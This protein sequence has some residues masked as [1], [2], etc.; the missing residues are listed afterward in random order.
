MPIKRAVLLLPLAIALIAAACGGGSDNNNSAGSDDQAR[1]SGSTAP[2]TAIGG[3]YG[4]QLTAI[5]EDIDQEF[6]A[7]S[8]EFDEVV[9][10]ALADLEGVTDAGELQTLLEE[11]FAK[12]F[13]A[14]QDFVP[15]AN[16]IIENGI[17]RI[18]ALDTP[19]EFEDDEQ[20]FL[21]AID[22]RLDLL[23]DL[24]E[25]A[26]D[27]D[28]EAFLALGQ[29]TTADDIDD[30]LRAAVSDDFRL[31]IAAFLDDDDDDD[32]DGDD[33]NT[34]SITQDDDGDFTIT[35]DDGTL[36]ID[37]DEGRLTVTDDDGTTTSIT[38]GTNGNLPD[39]V[40]DQLRYPNAV[41]ASA[42]TA[43]IDDALQIVL[44]FSTN[45]DPEDVLDFYEDALNAVGIRGDVQRG[46]IGGL[47]SLAI[48][49]AQQDG[50]GVI[51]AE[52]AGQ[53]ASHN[54]SVVLALPQ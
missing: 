31:L 35:S 15:R 29:S 46:E 1:S 3:S 8:N 25:I 42:I 4:E 33:G 10:D 36:D 43:Q 38:S 12:V 2:S 24:A 51:V 9:D 23:N 19:E 45:D 26:D 50:A 22:Q 5:D 52:N 34:T 6:D 30:T 48:G 11:S 21:D 13:N 39:D 28:V 40:P 49:D 47:F 54:V 44:S 32:D 16:D 14:T 53:D 27:E 37:S 17:E 18:E 20:A 41:G 7:L